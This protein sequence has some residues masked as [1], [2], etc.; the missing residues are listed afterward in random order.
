TGADVLDGLGGVLCRCTGYA[1]IVSAVSAVATGA[2]NADVAVVEPMP[3][4]GHAVGARI[5]RLDGVPKV[6]GIE[7]FGDGLAHAASRALRAV[8]SPHARARFTIRDLR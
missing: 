3:A 4:V 5:A 6:T 1:S 2:G 7:A 8:R